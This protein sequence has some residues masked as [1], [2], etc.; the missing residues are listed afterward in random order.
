MSK[1]ICGMWW[2]VVAAGLVVPAGAG[3]SDKPPGPP[4]QAAADKKPPNQEP[5][6]EKDKAKPTQREESDKTLRKQREDE[7]K[8]LLQLE[9]SEHRIKRMIEDL[10]SDSTSRRRAAVGEIGKYINAVPEGKKRIPVPVLVEM[11]EKDP[12]LGVRADTGCILGAIGADAKAAVPILA[13]A[14]KD[15]K[16]ADKTNVYP[17]LVNFGPVAVDA[18][19]ELI[20]VLRNPDRSAEYF[21]VLSVLKGIGPG[22]KDAIP[23]LLELLRKPPQKAPPEA[24]M[25]DPKYLC[26]LKAS[27]LEVLGSIRAMPERCVPAVVVNALI[28]EGPKKGEPRDVLRMREAA[29]RCLGAFG[30]EARGSVAALAGLL[31]KTSSSTPNSELIMATLRQIGP[32]AVPTLLGLLENG[33]ERVRYEAVVALGQIGPS[34]KAALPRLRKLLPSAEERAMG[35][36]REHVVEAIRRIEN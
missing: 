4:A 29:V 24:K 3:C 26:W 14:L 25:S 21:P 1:N 20:A 9:W 16:Y 6:Q 12:D 5:S 32:E 34:A 23:E 10:R 18:V 11:L 30:A 8:E 36:R 22:G 35:D 33:N 27:I 2:A 15:P 31:D 19:P 28:A 13:K 17:A 7:E